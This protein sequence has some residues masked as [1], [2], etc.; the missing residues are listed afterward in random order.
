MTRDNIMIRTNRFKLVMTALI[1]VMSPAFCFAEKPKMLKITLGQST[2]L[3]STSYLNSASI[4]VSRTG[5]VAAFYP[6]D[7]KGFSYRISKDGGL[8]WES[9]I[10]P[11]PEGMLPNAC[12]TALRE[13]G[14]IK[15]IGLTTRNRDG[16][17]LAGPL[18]RFNDDFSEYEIDIVPVHIPNPQLSP[19][20]PGPHTWA[21]PI[22]DKGKMIQLP[23]GEI[24]APSAG[25]FGDDLTGRAFLFSSKDL[26]R[27]W[28]YYSTIAFVKKYDPH[29]EFPGQYIGYAEPSIALTKDGKMIFI[30][31]TQGSHL[32]PDYKP[33]SIAWSD[34]YGKT[35]TDP[36]PTEPQLMNIWPTLIA[37][38]NGVLACVYGRPGFH[39][40]FSLDNGHTW[41]NRI[42][43]SH[44]Y[45]PQITGQVDGDKVGPNKLL[46]IGG[47]E[48]GTMV[49]PVTVELVDDPHPGNFIVKGQVINSDGKPIAGA[50]IQ[51]G[52]NRYT[53]NYEPIKSDND[54]PVTQTDKQGQFSFDNCTRSEHMITIEADG[55]ASQWQNFMLAPDM[56]PLSFTLQPGNVFSGKIID[57]NNK[58]IPGVCFITEDGTDWHCHTDVTG[59]FYWVSKGT[60]PENIKFR[61]IKKDYDHRDMTIDIENLEKPIV[62][63]SLGFLDP[64]ICPEITIAR[65][66]PDQAPDLEAD[67]D[68]PKWQRSPVITNF[69]TESI[70]DAKQIPIK[71]KFACDEKYIYSIIKVGP[72]P[73]QPLLDE[74]MI[75]LTFAM[76]YDKLQDSNLLGWT[77]QFAYN[78]TGRIP[79]T[80]GWNTPYP[81]WNIKKN[82]DG[83]WTLSTIIWW[84]QLG[85]APHNMYEPA[86][87]G[88]THIQAVGDQDKMIS[89]PPTVFHF[90]KIVIK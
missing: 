67:F 83:S 22:F 70:N 79:G 1:C 66:Y 88:I 25:S 36:V 33:M 50:K 84:L 6:D 85:R 20:E 37:L 16:L 15:N 81:K 12:S 5:V 19:K 14:V 56:S 34:D 23:S 7:Q 53:T 28:Y 41:Q 71:A 90:G 82:D 77:H 2:K 63:H 62:M 35:W 27:S 55:Y 48:Q 73:N 42:S 57:E 80:F 29:P 30:A 44:L 31:R 68:D 43:F 11:V 46:A 89:N 47:T 52:S 13:G 60:K 51:L 24:L 76:D 3:A 78:V 10:H 69:Q 64:N 9:E 40:A 38:D 74:D 45:E 26:G 32:P 75:E 54:S 59:T 17:P 58:P 86:V 49:F 61:L 8:T 18:I 4:A 39:V 21:G 72:S 65:I 87:I